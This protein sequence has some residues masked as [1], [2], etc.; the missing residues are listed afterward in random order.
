MNDFAGKVVLITGAG[1]G[2][3]RA[4][5]EAFTKRGAIVAANA[6]TPI[7]LDETIAQVRAFGGQIQAYVADFASKLALQS[8]LNEIV[9]QY[10]RVDILVQTAG[11]EPPDLFLE[12]DE[13]DWRRTLDINLT[14][15]FLL[16]QSVGR[17]MRAQGGGVMV[18]LVRVGNKDGVATPSKTG[19]LTLTKALATEFGD[20]NIRVNGIRCGAA[21]KAPEAEF[22]ENLVDLVLF[23]CSDKS[24]GVDGKI[25]DVT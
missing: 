10:G 11:V 20:H 5:A 21:I 24:G 2:I 25:F 6:L 19:L 23:L 13:W 14:G 22:P 17:V 18:N 12:M 4:L 7:N 15:P 8:M 3:G 9:D 16:L 1:E